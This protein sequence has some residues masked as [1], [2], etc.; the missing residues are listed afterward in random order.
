MAEVAQYLTEA[1]AAVQAEIDAEDAE[2]A[3]EA[4]AAETETTTTEKP[5]ETTE[6]VTT[7]QTAVVP[8]KTATTETATTTEKPAEKA[9]EA[10]HDEPAQPFVPVMVGEAP[11]DFDKRMADL[12]AEKVALAQRLDDG[13]LTTKE[14]TEKVE[15][16]TEQQADLRAQK[17]EAENAEQQNVANAKALW[18]NA[19]DGY[20]DAHP[21]LSKPA[22]RGAWDASL[23]QLLQEKGNETKSY[24]WH[25]AE[26]HKRANAELGI[27]K[28]ASTTTTTEAPAAP[29][30]PDR[31][32]PPAPTTL[33]HT[34]TAAPTNTGTSEFDAIDKLDGMAQE[35]AIAR[36]EKQDP[37]KYQRWLAG[38]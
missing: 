21:E 10:A 16:V 19:V 30:K 28:A 37:D 13:E 12:K 9:T 4:K 24:Y 17:R 18:E 5:A 27:G 38:G 7:T 22:M 14:W 20:T 3:A 31:R 36:M 29:A 35:A 32:P 15:A 11:T 26:A 25:L 8:D 34:P 33:A 2:A 23:K 6:T 1:E